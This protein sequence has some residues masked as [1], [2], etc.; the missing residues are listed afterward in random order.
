MGATVCYPSESEVESYSRTVAWNQE[1]WSAISVELTS[2]LTERVKDT[3]LDF[4]QMLSVSN[5]VLEASHSH[6]TLGC[7]AA[8]IVIRCTNLIRLSVK[9][10]SD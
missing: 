10:G 5:N 8:A 2:R 6:N 3:T 4:R 9:I 7:L 1:L